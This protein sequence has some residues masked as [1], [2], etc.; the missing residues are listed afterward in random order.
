MPYILHIPKDIGH[1]ETVGIESE[2]VREFVEKVAVHE[3]QKADGERT[4]A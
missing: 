3:K 2:I 4:Q 1:A